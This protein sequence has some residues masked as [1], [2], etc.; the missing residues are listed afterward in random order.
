MPESESRFDTFV[1]IS[2]VST[3]RLLLRQSYCLIIG[4]RLRGPLTGVVGMGKS[5]LVIKV[6]AAVFAVGVVAVSY[7]NC[8]Q[9][10]MTAN[11][12]PSSGDGNTSASGNNA[13]SFALSPDTTLKVTIA[14]VTSSKSQ[15]MTIKA[16][17]EAEQQTAAVVT[18]DTGGHR[19]NATLLMNETNTLALPCLSTNQ[20]PAN[21]LPC[22]A[23]A[24]AGYAAA[25]GGFRRATSFFNS[26]HPNS[27]A[28]GTV[29]APPGTPACEGQNM[30]LTSTVRTLAKTVANKVQSAAM[31]RAGAG[32]AVMNCFPIPDWVRKGKD[33]FVESYVTDPAAKNAWIAYLNSIQIN[34]ESAEATASSRG[35]RQLALAFQ[36]NQMG[37][38]FLQAGTIGTCAD[39]NGNLQKAARAFWAALGGLCNSDTSAPFIEANRSKLFYYRTDLEAP[40]MPTAALTADAANA[41]LA[42]FNHPDNSKCAG[43]SGTWM[44]VGGGTMAQCAAGQVLIDEPGDATILTSKY[45]PPANL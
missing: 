36:M 10:L 13:S 8:G 39:R 3:K 27:P 38:S 5:S 32:Q 19:A 11:V 34:T 12:N 29:T 14:Q 9:G 28:T 35:T 43:A 18:N 42:K 23:V 2:F 22:L 37:N 44:N 26:D 41:L 6:L 31:R 17:A 16:Q 7:T 33:T 1:S 24:R 21:P 4:L 40:R 25:S 45:D 20:G 15:T 30:N